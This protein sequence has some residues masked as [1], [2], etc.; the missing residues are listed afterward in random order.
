[1]KNYK[2]LFL[3]L[4]TAFFGCSD[5]QEE[6]VGLLSPN[7]F[8]KTPD[9]LQIAVN[10]AIGNMA[11]EAYW[12]RK[13][14][15]SLLLRSDMATI[16]DQGT[17]AARKEVNYFE[18]N[19]QSGMVSA[20]WPRS[21]EIIASANEAIA[22]AAL[23]SGAPEKINAIKGQAYFIRAFTYYHLVRLFG[24]IPYLDKPV[25]NV[26]ESKKISKTPAAKVYENIIADLQE[27]K[28]TLPNAQTNRSLPSKATASAYLASV[29]LTLGEFK[30][31]YDEAKYVIDNENNFQLNL[32]PDF[33][34]LFNANKQAALKE[35]LFVI[36]FNGFQDNNYGMD[37]MA[38]LTGIRQDQRVDGR[39][40][41]GEGWS[42]SVPTLKVF[43]TWD[44]RDYRRAVSFD[45]VAKF[46]GVIQ[47]YTYFPT[48]DK[49]NIASAYIAKYNRFPGLTGGANGRASS[50]RYA[51]MRYAEVLLIAAEALNE[52][53]PGTTEADGYVNR[54]RA[55]AR[56]RAGVMKNFPTNVTPGMSKDAFRTMVLEERRMELAFEFTRWYDIQRRQLGTQAFG[57]S[58]L[59]PQAKFNATRDYLFPL[60]GPELDRNPNLKPNNP[61]Y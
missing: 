43:T 30:K 19:D 7:G 59:E 5:L 53:T 13:L 33:Q 49:R 55:R 11:S 26:E 61:G 54:V 56:N 22:G 57:P 36:G 20:F 37:Y 38:S 25:T 35:P 47:P 12:G 8:F 9:D 1:M 50:I 31:A 29:Y 45:T 18:M 23:V 24:D 6:P 51:T 15:V 39:T 40:D 44:E 52:V 4:V 17:S 42:V 10:G 28:N 60:P 46:K 2:Y 32:E 14:T 34:N 3:L 41:I 21:Y 16:A 48:A 27:A 58:G